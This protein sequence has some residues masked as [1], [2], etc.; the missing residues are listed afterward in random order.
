MGKKYLCSDNLCVSNIK[1]C[2]V[3]IIIY[4]NLIHIKTVHCVG[5]SLLPSPLFQD[6]NFCQILFQRQTRICIC[7]LLLFIQMIA[8]YATKSIMLFFNMSQIVLIQYIQSIQFILTSCMYCLIVL[9][10]QTSTLFFYCYTQYCNKC[11]HMTYVCVGKF[12][13]VNR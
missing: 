2:L 9:Y 5:F 10:C 6:H 11:L 13:D 4:I 1:C 12:L 8:Y 7:V 3:P